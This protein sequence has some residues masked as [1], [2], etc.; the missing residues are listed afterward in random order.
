MQ[1][2]SEQGGHFCHR[3]SLNFHT[4]YVELACQTACKNLHSPGSLKARTLW[5][6]GIKSICPK[7]I[8]NLNETNQTLTN[9]QPIP[10]NKVGEY[11]KGADGNI[12][13][14]IEYND[15]KTL[16]LIVEQG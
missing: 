16:Y 13:L 12:T 7:Q 1:H 2:C 14:P 6:M 8:E 4:I 5:K 9:V 3:A 10:L 15:V 11:C